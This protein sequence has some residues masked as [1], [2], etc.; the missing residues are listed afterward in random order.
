MKAPFPGCGALRS[1]LL[2]ILFSAILAP[3]PAEAGEHSLG[4]G[5]HFW[6]TV[7]EIADDGDFSGIEDDGSAFVAS[8]RYKPGGLIFFQ[9]DFDYYPD[10]YGGYS[11]NTYT[12]MVF[13]GVG[14]TWYVAAGIAYTHTDKVLHIGDEEFSSGDS[15][16]L[17]RIGWN[18]ELLPRVAL[19]LNASYEIDAWNAVDQLSSDATTLGAVVR[20]TF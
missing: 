20:F 16:F 5:V 4:L 12:P 17:G 13:V 10:G 15:Y 8:Y 2:P 3:A 14:R 7:D 18:L 9:I 11:G 1:F 6:K 19:D